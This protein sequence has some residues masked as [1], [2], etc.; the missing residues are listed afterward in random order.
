MI[1]SPSH[2]GGLPFPIPPSPSLSPRVRAPSCRVQ[3][4]GRRSAE[5]AGLPTMRQVDIWNPGQTSPCTPPLHP[6]T[7]GCRVR[8]GR[9]RGG[10]GRELGEI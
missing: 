9:E 6:F 10:D 4:L 8:G 7:P 3:V 1:S 2:K 5:Q